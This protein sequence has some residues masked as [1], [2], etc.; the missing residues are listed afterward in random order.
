MNIL[1]DLDGLRAGEKQL[2][3]LMTRFSTEWKQS[4]AKIN[5]ETLS[6]FPNLKLG[7]GKFLEVNRGALFLSCFSL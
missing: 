1:G 6:S 3:Q 7:T 5:S 2:T 4:L